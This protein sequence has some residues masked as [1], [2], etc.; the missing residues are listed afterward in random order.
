MDFGSVRGND[1]LEKIKDGRTITSV[2]GYNSYLIIVD[3]A[4]RYMFTF[5]TKRKHPP[6]DIMK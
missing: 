3:K 6:L 4:S 5:L 1:F 2:D